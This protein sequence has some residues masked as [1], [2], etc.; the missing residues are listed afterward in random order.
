MAEG[1]LH[2]L[3]ER[4]RGSEIAGQSKVKLMQYKVTGGAWSKLFNIRVVH[5]CMTVSSQSLY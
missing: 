1:R 2:T 4:G 3:I 5:K